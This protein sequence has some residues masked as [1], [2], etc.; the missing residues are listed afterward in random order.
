MKKLTWLLRIVGSIQIFLGLCYLISPSVFLSAMGHSVP[1]QD[2]HYPLAMLAARFI[3][4]GIAFIYISNKPMLHKL[5]IQFM[6]LIQL[7]DLAAG[8][9]YTTS[10][11][12]SLSLS[13]FPM[14]NALW[15]IVLLLLWQPKIVKA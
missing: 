14:F 11:V 13:G 7:I 4:Y 3:A 10:G 12:V 6:V 15:I 1:E 8:I 5:W 2:I 9:F